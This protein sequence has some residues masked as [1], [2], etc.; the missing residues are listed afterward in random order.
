MPSKTFPLSLHRPA[1]H[2]AVDPGAE[3]VVEGSLYSRHDGSVIDGATTTWSSA[4]PGGGSV[5][6]TGLFDFTAGGLRLV[7]RDPT[8]HLARVVAT[9]KDAPGC[10]QHGVAAPCLLLRSSSLAHARLLTV[11]EWAQSLEGSLTLRMN[12]PPITTTGLVPGDFGQ[13]RG[14]FTG[15]WLGCGIVVLMLCGALL[16]YRRRVVC[17][18]A[19]LLAV[20]RRVRRTVGRLDPVLSAALV[21]AFTATERAIRRR[22]L[23]PASTHG[24]RVAET[25]NR[26]EGDLL[27]AAQHQRA[28]AQRQAANHLIEQVSLALEAAREVARETGG[29]YATQADF[30]GSA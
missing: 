16:W 5:D 18:R 15:V 21:P 3:I 9:G 23:D 17:P 6:A 30:C 14:S 7:S 19:R 4:A 13:A 29:D 1:I 10:A 27:Q 28:S 20:L 22:H 12:V 26:L 25:F 8:T 2:V 24:Q 11:S